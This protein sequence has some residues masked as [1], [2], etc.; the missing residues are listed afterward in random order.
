HLMHTKY[1]GWLDPE[2]MRIVPTLIPPFPPGMKV[3][4]SDGTEGVTVGINPDRP[5]QPQVKRI[6]TWEPL[7]LEQ[8]L[9][10]L[11]SAKGLES[12][13]VGGVS[14]KGMILSL[15]APAPKPVAA[16]APAAPAVEAG[17]PAAAPVPAPA[18]NAQTESNLLNVSA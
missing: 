12:T 6:R 5:Y 17:L 1:A 7:E 16:P 15:T 11:K 3:T 4:L 13:H 8:E 2:V 14:S 10:D 9:L 18:A